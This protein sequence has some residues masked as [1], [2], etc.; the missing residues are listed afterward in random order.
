M[1]MS[2]LALAKAVAVAMMK[3]ATMSGSMELYASAPMVAVSATIINNIHER[4]RPKNFGEKRS[5]IGDHRNFNI[6]GACDSENQP[7]AV[8][9]SPAYLSHGGIAI[10]TRPSG[11]PDANDCNATVANRRLVAASRSDASMPGRFGAVVTHAP[12]DGKIGD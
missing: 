5:M 4:L 6:H 8:T 2:R 9:S 1:T 12:Y 7:M 3:A 11:N 10:H